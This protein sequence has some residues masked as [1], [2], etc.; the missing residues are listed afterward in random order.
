MVF[1]SQKIQAGDRVEVVN[2]PD[3]YGRLEGLVGR[4]VEVDSEK[5][6]RV[7][8][9]KFKGIVVGCDGH[10]WFESYEIKSA[11]EPKK[12]V[13]KKK[14]K[15]DICYLLERLRKSPNTTSILESLPSFHR[16]VV[17]T[18]LRELDKGKGLDKTSKGRL[19]PL[20]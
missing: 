15:H 11:G 9:K 14:M 6:Y 3:E 5:G 17:V 13:V 10:I 20:T 1:V 4:V 12:R 19:N 18:L 8:N 7:F 2:M 16:K